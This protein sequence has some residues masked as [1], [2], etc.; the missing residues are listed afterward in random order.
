MLKLY[1]GEYCMFLSK[2]ITMPQIRAC[3]QI[4]VGSTH[5]VPV[6]L[7]SAW[8]NS[9]PDLHAFIKLVGIVGEMLSS[10][11]QD[12]HWSKVEFVRLRLD[13]LRTGISVSPSIRAQFSRTK[14][15]A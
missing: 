8:Y 6:Y 11:Y 1:G 13:K 7:A 4:V 14:A 5:T 15:P 9:N 10:R 2:Y 12:S 3:R